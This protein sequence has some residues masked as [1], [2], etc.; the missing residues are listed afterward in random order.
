[1]SRGL[2]GLIGIEPLGGLDPA[3]REIAQ[4]RQLAQRSVYYIQRAPGLLDMQVE[5]LVYQFAVA[6]ETRLLLED[7]N[8]IADAAQRAGLLADALPSVIAQEREAAITQISTQLNAQQDKTRALA[9]DLREMLDSGTHTADSIAT[10]I[11]ALDGLVSRFKSP[12]PP[13]AATYTD[14]P[15][16]SAIR[17]YTQLLR[18][19]SSTTDQL[20]G[21]IVTLDQRTAGVER[22]ASAVAADGKSVVDYFVIRAILLAA[23]IALI[24]VVSVVT[25]RV[26][27]KRLA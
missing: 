11:T 8:R 24:I 12:G 6:P 2:L 19:L 16:T 21:L 5:R 9:R 7:T 3:V 25:C 27:S 22:L 1:M 20:Q 17:D 26:V 14:A 18:E 4:A 15:K 23:A 13:V 10:T